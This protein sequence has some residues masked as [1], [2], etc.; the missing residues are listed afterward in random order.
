MATT[1][2]K[3]SERVIAA[4]LAWGSTE[5]GNGTGNGPVFCVAEKAARGNDGR[6][7]MQVWGTVLEFA[8]GGKERSIVLHTMV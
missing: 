7:E 1:T 4:P 6:T 2:A 5:E 8:F 3:A